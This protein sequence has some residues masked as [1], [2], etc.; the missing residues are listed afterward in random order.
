MVFAAGLGTRLRPLTDSM[1]KALV[2]VG[3][4]PLLW[5]VL[6]RLQAAGYTSVVVNV[7]HFAG[8]I[9]IESKDGLFKQ[10]FFLDDA[11]AQKK[12][13]EFYIQGTEDMNREFSYVMTLFENNSTE[14]VVKEGTWKGSMCMLPN[15]KPPQQQASQQPQPQQPDEPQQPQQSE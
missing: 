1:P 12:Q 9:V 7:H 10:L 8:Q 15:P 3:G 2:P 6:Q 5:H 4:H 13:F 14:P 11:V